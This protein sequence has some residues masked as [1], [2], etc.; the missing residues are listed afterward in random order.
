MLFRSMAW[1]LHHLGDT[2]AQPHF[3]AFDHPLIDSR[4]ARIVFGGAD[5]AAAAGLLQRQVAADVIAVMVG[6]EDMGQPPAAAAQRFQHRLG[7]CRIDRRGFAAV[8]VVQ[9]VDVVVVENR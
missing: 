4:Y 7:D 6:V 9:Q 5:D 3:I 8:G 2:A 1:H